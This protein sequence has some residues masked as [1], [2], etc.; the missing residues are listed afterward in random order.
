MAPGRDNLLAWYDAPESRR[1]ILFDVHQDTVPADGM[2]IPPFV[3]EIAGGPAS[4]AGLVR[5]QGVDGGDAVGLRPAGARAAAGLGVGAPGL[6][7]RR[8][9]HAH[10]LVAAGRDR[11]TGPSWRSS[12]SRP[13]STWSIATRAR[14]G[15][16]SGP[17]ASPATARRRTWASTPS[18][19][20]AGSSTSSRTY[21]GT[22]AASTPDP[23]LGPP[24]PVG[25][26][27]RGGTERQRRP[28]L[29]RDRGRPPPDP[30]RRRRVPPWTTVE[31]A[32][33]RSSSSEPDAS[34]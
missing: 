31:R 2:T 17:R 14:C 29:V 10:R 9:V 8:R 24:T 26:P 20:W 22:L 5:R 6:H 21:A 27:D 34:N 7:G 1:L 19:G 33:R 30:G 13:R 16:R 11:T 32:G 28:R 23:I 12:P 4:R 25:R 15:G 18:T 3:P